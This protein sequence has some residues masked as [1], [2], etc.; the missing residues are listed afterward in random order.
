VRAAE[1][2]LPSFDFDALS[3]WFGFERTTPTMLNR[4]E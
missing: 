1:H 4:G 3:V 2:R